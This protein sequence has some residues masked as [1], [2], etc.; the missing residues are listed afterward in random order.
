MYQ[1]VIYGIS[2]TFYSYAEY[3]AAVDT[4]RRVYNSD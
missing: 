3:A 1:L 4:Y 2:Y